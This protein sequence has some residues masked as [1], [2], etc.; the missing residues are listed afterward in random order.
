MREGNS[1]REDGDKNSGTRDIVHN[2]CGG[3]SGK[4]VRA[5]KA[6]S[7]RKAKP[8]ILVKEEQLGERVN[9]NFECNAA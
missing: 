6:L 9:D 2:G 3:T 1:Q 4:E 5:G 7:R 8:D